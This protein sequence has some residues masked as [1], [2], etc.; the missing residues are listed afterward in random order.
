[1]G[2]M[3]TQ[4]IVAVSGVAGQFSRLGLTNPACATPHDPADPNNSPQESR[5][6]QVPFTV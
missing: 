6:L 1:M 5:D 3:M 2:L 4:L